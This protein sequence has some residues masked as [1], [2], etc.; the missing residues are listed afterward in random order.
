MFK[1]ATFREELLPSSGM[2]MYYEYWTDKQKYFW[3][4]FVVKVLSFK[5]NW[6][7]WSFSLPKQG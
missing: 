2:K 4:F 5:G 3:V 6:I 1:W 7:F